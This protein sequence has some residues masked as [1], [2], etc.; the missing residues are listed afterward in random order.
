M[1]RREC[2]RRESRRSSSRVLGP[3]SHSWGLVAYVRYASVAKLRLRYFLPSA[4][5][6][7]GIERRQLPQVLVK[8][9]IFVSSGSGAFPVQITAWTA[10]HAFERMHV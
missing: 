7:L 3:W 6:M 4:A 2:L 9:H 8:Y 5:R 10:H 1:Q